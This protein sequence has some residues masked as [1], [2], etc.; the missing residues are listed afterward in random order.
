MIEYPICN[1]CGEDIT[2]PRCVVM[3]ADDRMATCFCIRCKKKMIA[4]LV[5]FSAYAAELWRDELEE[6][7][8]ATPTR[9]I[10]DIG[11]RT[12]WRYQS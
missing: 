12:T 2:D 8:R 1:A 9:M 4:A 3:D 5:P 10:Y 6:H 7:E 11:E